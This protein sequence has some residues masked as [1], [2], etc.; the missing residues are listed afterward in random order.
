[1][2][3]QGVGTFVNEAHELASD[4][5][6]L[7][8]VPPVES[9]LV[10]GKQITLYPSSRLTSDGPVEFLIPSDSTDFT[11][12]NQTRLEGEITITKVDGTALGD[13]DK[14]SI[15]NLFP[16]SIW[17]QI[18]CSIGDVQIND[19]STPSYPYKA[20]L[21]THLSFN[22]DVKNTSLKGC[23]YY[24]K[25]DIG[26]ENTLTLADTNDVKANTAFVAKTAFFKKNKLYF[27]VQLHI[28]FFQCPKFLIPGVEVKLKFIRSDDKFS[29]LTADVDCKINIK[30]LVL[31]VRRITADPTILGR[32]ETQLN[33][34]PAIYP[35]CK[36]VVKTYLLQSATKNHRISQFIRGKLPRSFMLGLVTAKGYD[37]DKATNPFVFKNH[38]LNYL[39]I[40]INGEPL[41]PQVF[42]PDFANG[43]YVREYAWFLDNIGLNHTASIGVTKEEFCANTCLFPFDLSPDK[44]NSVYLHGV[45]N[46][47][48]DIDL[49]FETTPAENLYCIMYASYDELVTIDKNRS[50]AM[51]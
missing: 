3:K 12:L 35:I 18:E 23:G 50:V 21:E 51:T 41:V 5:L 49:G 26:R 31:K 25:D 16:Q 30:D 48:I 8:S 39:N 1:M 29:I 6:D 15:V 9:A 34:T 11:A 40:L 36:S 13:A 14:I 33:S 7:F 38:T 27:S 42:Q 45:E 19:L 24:V 46:G 17:K 22:E 43:K 2:D 4:S 28:D 20:F 10:H 44:C 47:T 32:I 37:G